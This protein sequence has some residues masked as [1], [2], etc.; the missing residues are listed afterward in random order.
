MEHH[1]RA[2]VRWNRGGADFTDRKYSRGHVWSFDGGAQVAASS[3]PL[4]V[5]LPHSIAA[6]VDPEEALVA[7]LASCHMLF[8]LDFAARRGF[9]IDR[10]EDAAV[11]TM[12]KNEQGK[13]F[14]ARVELNPHAVFTGAQR[15][16]QQDVTA[17]HHRAHEE[18]Y[19]ANSVK[20]EV[21]VA[22]ASFSFADG[23][24]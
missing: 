9:V 15:P 12:G 16:T 18:C 8:F 20:S 17:L 19:I 2:S 4:N 22:A 6:A 14:I 23:N 10:Y 1:Y 5:L 21:A 13:G 3:S 7:A 24:E 11:G